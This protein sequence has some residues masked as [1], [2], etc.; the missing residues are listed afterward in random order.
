MRR[1]KIQK[2]MTAKYPEDWATPLGDDIMIISSDEVGPIDD[3][4]LTSVFDLQFSSDDEE[5]DEEITG[6][7]RCVEMKM[8]DLALP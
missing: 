2:L 5:T 1:K 6:M 4:S 8:S 3:L 7:V